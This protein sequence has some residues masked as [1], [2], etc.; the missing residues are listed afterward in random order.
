MA[1]G[2]EIIFFSDFLELK[3]K[4]VEDELEMVNF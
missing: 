4:N 1:Q 2:K 3:C